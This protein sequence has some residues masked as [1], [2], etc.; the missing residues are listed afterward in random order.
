[1]ANGYHQASGFFKISLIYNVR[2]CG[3]KFHQFETDSNDNCIN[4]SKF[5]ERNFRG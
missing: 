4:F 3:S 5:V 2:I 1:M